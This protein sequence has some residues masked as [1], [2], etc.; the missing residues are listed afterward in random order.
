MKDIQQPV[1][2]LTVQ[3]HVWELGSQ[4]R[5]LQGLE[6]QQVSKRIHHPRSKGRCSLY[7]LQCAATTASAVS[8]FVSICELTAHIYA[9]LPCMAVK[10][11]FTFAV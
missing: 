9:L 6:G 7:P 8:L 5:E 1:W 3:Q 11:C 10:L 4:D 2:L